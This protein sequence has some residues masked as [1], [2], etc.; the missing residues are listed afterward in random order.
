M[1]F[2]LTQ[3]KRGSQQFWLLVKSC[4][5][6]SQRMPA[7]ARPLWEQV[8]VRNQKYI[9]FLV[10]V[11]WANKAHIVCTSIFLC[12]FKS[13]LF[14]SAVQKHCCLLKEPPQNPC[15][16]FSVSYTCYHYK[17][18]HPKVANDMITEGFTEPPHG[19]FP[20][21][22]AFQEG[23]FVLE[24]HNVSADNFP[25][26]SG[27]RTQP[28]LKAHRQGW[29]HCFSIVLALHKFHQPVV[30]TLSIWTGTDILK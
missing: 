26:W 19:N 18:R 5:T 15:H 29:P 17:D 20:T 6:R 13:S 4:Q 10:S 23:L 28:P 24:L 16:F 22:A 12:I 14:L 1:N 21:M 2:P 8:I 7:A 25:C 27:G 9:S 3:F 30:I 11:K